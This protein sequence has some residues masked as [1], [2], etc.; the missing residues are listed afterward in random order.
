[1]SG[2]SVRSSVRLHVVLKR[3]RAKLVAAPAV[4]WSATRCSLPRSASPSG[5]AW[6][7]ASYWAASLFSEADG[8]YSGLSVVPKI[9]AWVSSRE[10]ASLLARRIVLFL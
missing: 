4:P 3:A 6:H 2:N 1:M 5:T 10:G 9:S 8:R 7:L